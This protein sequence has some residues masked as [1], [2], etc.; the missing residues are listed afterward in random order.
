MIGGVCGVLGSPS[1]VSSG[2]VGP[3]SGAGAGA[4][5]G[6]QSPPPPPD[7]P[8]PPL[9][10]L[11]PPEDPPRR[12]P[13]P[14]DP[15]GSAGGAGVSSVGSASVGSSDSLGVSEGLSLGSSLGVGAPPPS[16][17]ARVAG[18]V[19]AGSG[20]WAGSEVSVGSASPASAA[21]GPIP[22]TPKPVTAPTPTML[23]TARPRRRPWRP[24]SATL[25]RIPV[26]RRLPFP[27][28]ID[29]PPGLCCVLSAYWRRPSL[30]RN[31]GRAH[32]GSAR[33]DGGIRP[34]W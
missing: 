19:S 2:V 32:T 31:S 30:S 23:A 4:G 26:A 10:P 17:G 16:E 11:D 8:D 33:S 28:P 12:S 29:A 18:S 9:P 20:D 5:A 21:S 13:S 15:P 7:P 34:R 22:A 6:V 1:G 14:L 27:M 24:G 3:G 25:L